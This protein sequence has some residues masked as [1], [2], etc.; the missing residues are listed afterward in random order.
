[1]RRRVTEITDAETLAVR[2]PGN[3]AQ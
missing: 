2:I 1:L 3:E